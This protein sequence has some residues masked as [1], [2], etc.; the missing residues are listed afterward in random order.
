MYPV[1]FGYKNVQTLAARLLQM[2]VDPDHSLA[3][4]LFVIGYKAI[5]DQFI[6]SWIERADRDL[7]HTI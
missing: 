3:N 4:L 1:I 7:D 5:F 2:I 6:Q